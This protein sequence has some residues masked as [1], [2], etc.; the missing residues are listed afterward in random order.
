[1]WL[2]SCRKCSP[3]QSPSAAPAAL[4]LLSLSRSAAVEAANRARSTVRNSQCTSCSSSILKKIV[5]NSSS[6]ITGC[7]VV[8]VA[9]IA[10]MYCFILLRHSTYSVSLVTMLDTMCRMMV[11]RFALDILRERPLLLLL[12][13]LLVA[14]PPA[15]VA[16]LSVASFVAG[17]VSVEIARISMGAEPRSASPSL[18][19]ELLRFSLC[20]VGRIKY[21]MFT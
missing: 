11:L 18:S 19:I 12:L 10:F 1:M 14:V 17:L 7:E 5:W 9:R 4:P 6:D 15:P 8:S 2:A 13:P 20:C 21:S 3:T 16:K